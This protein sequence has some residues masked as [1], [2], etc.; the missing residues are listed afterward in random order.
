[1]DSHFHACKEGLGSQIKPIWIVKRWKSKPKYF[2][3]LKFE[4]FTRNLKKIKSWNSIGAEQL[5]TL[6]PPFF[7]QRR[8]PGK[9]FRPLDLIKALISGIIWR[10]RRIFVSGVSPPKINHQ[11]HNSLIIHRTSHQMTSCNYE[12]Q[13]KKGYENP[14]YASTELALHSREQWRRWSPPAALS[15][16]TPALASPCN[17]LYPLQLLPFPV[18]SSGYLPLRLVL[19]PLPS[20]S[21][22]WW[23]LHPPSGIK[24]GF[25]LF[26]LI[27][28]FDSLISE[29][30]IA[31]LPY[32]KRRI[33]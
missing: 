12:S 25:F 31:S 10:L 20:G 19:L 13:S 5:K 26:I 11:D 1:M 6:A 16:V 24:V 28:E 2:K 14:S 23:L 27:F 33:G 22:A 8:K 4:K 30:M 9:D 17:P 18:V 21:H 29:R 32:L 3:S 15:A 7:Q